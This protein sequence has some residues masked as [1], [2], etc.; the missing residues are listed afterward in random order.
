MDT[1]LYEVLSDWKAKTQYSEPTDWTFASPE[2]HGVQP[3]WPDSLRRKIMQPA[4]LRAGITKQVGWHTFRHSYATLLM[5][6]GENVKV[7][8]E[9]LRHANS[10]ITLETYT[11]GTMSAKQAAQGNV[12]QAIRAPGT[13]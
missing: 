13:A 10:R 5:M 8:Q 1:G 12:I 6:N 4:V 3:Y 11:Q 2:M 9:S 7:I